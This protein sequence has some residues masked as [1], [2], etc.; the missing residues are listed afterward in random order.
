MV[1]PSTFESD[2]GIGNAR[3]SH[4]HRRFGG[5]VQVIDLALVRIETGTAG[6]HQLFILPR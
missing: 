3:W 1:H 6:D 4:I 2:G 5:D